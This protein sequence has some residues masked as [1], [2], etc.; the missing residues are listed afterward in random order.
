L[1][2]ELASASGRYRPYQGKK[3]QITSDEYEK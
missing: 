3:C 1:N 2:N